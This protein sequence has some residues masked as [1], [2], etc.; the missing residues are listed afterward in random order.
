MSERWPFE[1][2][3]IRLLD[4]YCIR[5]GVEQVWNMYTSAILVNAPSLLLRNMLAIQLSTSVGNVK[6]SGKKISRHCQPKCEKTGV[7]VKKILEQRDAAKEK[8]CMLDNIAEKMPFYNIV[9]L[10]SWQELDMPM[11]SAQPLLL[12]CWWCKQLNKSKLE[13]G[14]SRYSGMKSDIFT[15]GIQI[16]EPLSYQTNQLCG[17]WIL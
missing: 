3:T 4:V 8:L 15:A 12:G 5:I 17:C 1:S 6:W 14:L 9:Y 2:W 11:G 7:G 10:I 13:S 16:P